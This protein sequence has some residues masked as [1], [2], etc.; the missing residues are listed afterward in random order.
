M[1]RFSWPCRGSA[2][3]VVERNSLT[4]HVR[5][6]SESTAPEAKA[7]ADPHTLESLLSDLMQAGSDERIDYLSSLAKEHLNESALTAFMRAAATRSKELNEEE[8]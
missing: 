7:E 3:E 2:P 1:Y 5:R 8:E 6:K 4:S